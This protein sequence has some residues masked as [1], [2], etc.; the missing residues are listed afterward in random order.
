MPRLNDIVCCKI[1]E[2]YL[3]FVLQHAVDIQV[4][5]VAV[6]EG[7]QVRVEV[8]HRKQHLVGSAV[9]RCDVVCV[10]CTE[11]AFDKGLHAGHLTLGG[12]GTVL[13][14]VEHVVHDERYDFLTELIL[15]NSGA[16]EHVGFASQV[17]ERML[18]T[19]AECGQPLQLGVL[20]AEM[21]KGDARLDSGC[22][23]HESVQTHEPHEHEL[24]RDRFGEVER[25]VQ[26]CVRRVVLAADLYVRSAEYETASC[27]IFAHVADFVAEPVL[28]DEVVCHA[29]RF[30]IR[31]DRVVLFHDA[32]RRV[33]VA[34]VKSL[35]PRNLLL[36]DS[37]RL[38]GVCLRFEPETR[39]LECLI[40]RCCCSEVFPDSVKR[41]EPLHDGFTDSLGVCV[42]ERRCGCISLVGCHLVFCSFELFCAF[43]INELLASWFSFETEVIILFRVMFC[44]SIKSNELA[45]LQLLSCPVASLNK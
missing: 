28:I 33:R 26:N 16:L 39:N 31:N 37:R 32:Q 14:A 41:R 29:E 30:R 34:I 21:C 3:H 40:I 24:H 7:A 19:R 42:E 1:C 17:I 35:V 8:G 5:V 23:T 15:C 13:V 25:V 45:I 9:I 12:C 20:V 4:W 43:I 44:L 2:G 36:A 18:E 11:H 22:D 10:V 6:D 27:A 38:H